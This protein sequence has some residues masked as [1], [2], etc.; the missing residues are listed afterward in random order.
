[1]V[2]KHRLLRDAFSLSFVRR[3]SWRMLSVEDRYYKLN[4]IT[5]KILGLWPYRNSKWTYIQVVMIT[6]MYIS[7]I[8][9]QVF[10]FFFDSS[11]T[12]ASI[13]EQNVSNVLHVVDI[14][15]IVL[16]SS[17][18]HSWLYHRLGRQCVLFRFTE[19]LHVLHVLHLLFLLRRSKSITYFPFSFHAIRY[20]RLLDSSRE[21]WS[22]YI[23]TGNFSKVRKN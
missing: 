7:A 4:R 8:F 19:C 12:F 22:M 14:I 23:S 21:L 11:L 5:L 10:A 3:L 16:V 6:I 1:M 13:R 9:V 18:C 2:V 17:I 20:N 15:I